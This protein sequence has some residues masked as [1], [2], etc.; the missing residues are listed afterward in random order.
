MHRF[1]SWIAA[2]GCGAL[3]QACG[4]GGSVEGSPPVAAPPPPPPTQ[5]ALDAANYQGAVRNAFEWGDSAFA[6]AKLGADVADHLL[7]IPL[8]LPPLF[9]CP[10]SGSAQASLSDRNRNRM[11]NAGDTLSLFMDRCTTGTVTVSGV[12]RVE[13][14]LAEP[15][16]NGRH[17]ELLV[18]I[19]NLELTSSNP[20]DVPMTINFSGTVD[21][22]Y[23]TDF[24][25]YVLTFGEYRRTIDGLTNNVTDLV[26]DY[27]QR[28]DT[29]RYDYLLQG[30]LAS[31]ATSGQ[32]RVTTPIAFSGT[33]GAFPSGGRLGLNGAANSTARLSEEGPAANN[34]AA[35]LVSVDANGDGVADSEVPELAWTQLSQAAM[36]SSL[37][38]RP[39]LGP[40]PIP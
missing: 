39:R 3:L 33:I 37:R 25:H 19:V 34:S 38:G 17:L 24:D 5:L 14:I 8:T 13:V 20:T 23:T 28:Y 16:G 9:G 4:G 35:V 21:F 40:L 11:L 18:Q 12:V 26:V 15:L 1:A 7:N 22:S 27:L 30:S 10:V 29:L 36:F 2:I 32:F 6:Y 31:S